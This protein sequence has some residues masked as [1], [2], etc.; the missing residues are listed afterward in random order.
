MRKKLEKLVNTGPGGVPTAHRDTFA[1]DLLPSS[2]QQPEY[3]F[4][5]IPELMA[6]D[7]YQNAA[8]ELLYE[9]VKKGFGKRPVIYFEDKTWTY[10]Q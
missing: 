1:R 7:D 10:D 8:Y 4:T 2:Q 9:M 6:Y 3:D 5:Q